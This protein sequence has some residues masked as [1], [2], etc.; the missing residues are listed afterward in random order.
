[1][2]AL[3]ALGVAFVFLW[4]A[5]GGLAHFV[6]TDAEMRAVPPYIPWPRAA[7]L[8]SGVFELAGAAGLLFG[9]TRHASGLGLF[10]LTIAVTPVH[11]HMLQ[12]PELFDVPYWALILRLPVQ[13][14]LLCLIWWCTRP[15]HCV[16]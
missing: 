16:R 11:I 15:W 13:A 9:H 10:I 6:F 14:A 5:I 2:R 8:W 7:V 4:F 1:M 12:R 3:K